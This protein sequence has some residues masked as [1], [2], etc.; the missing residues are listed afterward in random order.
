M[1]TLDTTTLQFL[2]KRRFAKFADI[3]TNGIGRI[4]LNWKKNFIPA[5]FLPF[6]IS[7]LIYI[8]TPVP[9]NTKN[10]HVQI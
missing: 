7:N 2:R 6:K 4:H 1:I 8:C 5:N 9:L 10:T 3:A